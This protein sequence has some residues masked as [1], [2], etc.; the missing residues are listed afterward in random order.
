MKP[1]NASIIFE[2]RMA[3]LNPRALEDFVIRTSRVAGLHGRTSVLI[4]GNSQIRRLNSSF[5]N[6]NSATDVLSFPA[7]EPRDGLA[8]EIA[9]SLDIAARN[10]KMLGHSVSVEI[11]I[12]IL[13]GILHLAGYDHENDQGEMRRKEAT[14]RKKLGLPAGLIDRNSAHEARSSVVRRGSSVNSRGSSW[15][16]T[17]LTARDAR[18]LRT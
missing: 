4:T 17:R 18:R 7:S 10:A 9:V 2:K 16:G 12:L 1:R 11:R 14:L 6:K 8:G 15:S 3:G 5:R 13:H